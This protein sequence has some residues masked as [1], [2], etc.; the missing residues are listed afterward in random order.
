MAEAY[1]YPGRPV[2]AGDGRREVVTTVQSR[3]DVVGC[4]PGDIDG[5]FGSA[6]R[7]AVQQ[8]QSRR[9]LVVDGAVGAATWQML[10]DAVPPP[11][12]PPDGF[13]TELLRMAAAE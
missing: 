11:K 10:F 5:I 13:A 12:G 6:T 3:L 9:G 4:D 2:R 1:L 7:I 8:F